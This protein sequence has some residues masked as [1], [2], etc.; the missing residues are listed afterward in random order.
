MLDTTLNALVKVF[1]TN[2]KPRLRQTIWT[3]P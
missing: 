2:S 3:P 1:S